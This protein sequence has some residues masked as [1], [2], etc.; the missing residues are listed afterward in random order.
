[1]LKIVSPFGTSKR[2]GHTLI[3]DE[4]YLKYL[5][6]SVSEFIFYVPNYSKEILEIKF[7]LGNKN[8]LKN[9]SEFSVARGDKFVFLGYTELQL[10]RYFLFFLFCRCRITLIATN[11]FSHGRFERKK[12]YLK[13]IYYI[14]NFFLD[15]LVVHTDFERQLIDRYL[16]F[17]S[18]KIFIKRHHMMMSRRYH[19]SKNNEVLKI[20]FFGPVK[21][22]KPLEPFCDFINADVNRKFKY[23]FFNITCDDIAKI[24]KLILSLENVSYTTGWLDNESYELAITESDLLFL[25]HQSSFQGKLSGNLCEAIAYKKPYISAKMDPMKNLNEIYGKV[26]FLVDFGRKDWAV[27]LLNSITRQDLAKC[28]VAFEPYQREFTLVN[29]LRDLEI[30]FGKENLN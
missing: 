22:E 21:K 29:I 9:I 18:D 26:G 15:R 24:K 10:V 28:D 13:I 1:M 11:N 4:F 8:N 7:N 23:S 5:L 27:S 25:T 3:D 20:S 12:I 17:L 30:V 6:E 16:P 2:S 19:K 14:L